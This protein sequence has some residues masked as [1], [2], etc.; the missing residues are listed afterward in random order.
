ME[1]SKVGRASPA[2]TI[3]AQVPVYI[4]AAKHGIA[5]QR[6]PASILDA[7]GAAALLF[8][9]HPSSLIPHPT[10]H[11]SSRPWAGRP[12]FQLS[13]PRSSAAAIIYSMCLAIPGRILTQDG[14]YAV[15]DFGG[16]RRRIG[17]ALTPEA[18]IGDFVLVHAGMA[19]QIIDVAEA[20]RTLELI[21]A[22]YAELADEE[23]AVDGS[24]E[25]DADAPPAEEHDA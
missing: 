2:P 21:R 18:A 19:I 4:N 3:T 16:V 24:G 15:V 13:S 11:I 20:E 6:E 25:G 14:A 8:L 10:S 1:F 7:A 5:P 23:P 17:T 9:S 12:R 22:A